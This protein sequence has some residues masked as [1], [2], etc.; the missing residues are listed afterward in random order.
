[1]EDT[2]LY[3]CHSSKH[4]DIHWRFDKR[5]P[6][7]FYRLPTLKR[8]RRRLELFLLS[9]E[10][11]EADDGSVDEQAADD[12]HDHGFDADLFGVGQHDGEGWGEMLVRVAVIMSFA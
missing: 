5:A 9:E 6:P 11:G 2:W 12:A 4:L 3:T 8:F 7:K 10:H 1:M